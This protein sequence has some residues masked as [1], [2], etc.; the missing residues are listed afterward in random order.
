MR[1]LPAILVALLA[2]P[3]TSGAAE[4][5]NRS[6]PRYFRDHYGVISDRNIFSRNRPTERR[7]ERPRP[8][9]S[10]QRY[11]LVG[12]VRLEEWENDKGPYAAYVEDGRSEKTVRVYVGDSIANGKIARIDEISIDYESGGQTRNI[13]IG[14]NLLRENQIVRGEA[15]TMPSTQPSLAGA[16]GQD[17][18][19]ASGSG[20][21]EADILARLKARREAELKK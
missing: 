9:Q 5:T 12:I 16:D 8:V 18:T 3:L 17:S 7:Y 15:T 20:G 14:L 10:E 21:S 11:M 19:G 4:T 2:M 6:D 1:Y 13:E